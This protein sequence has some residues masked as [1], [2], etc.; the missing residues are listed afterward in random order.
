MQAKT[1]LPPQ[2]HLT[3]LLQL[4]HLEGLQRREQYD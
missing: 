2:Y 3:L 1:F 4:H